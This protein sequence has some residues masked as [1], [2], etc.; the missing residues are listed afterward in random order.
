M[1]KHGLTRAEELAE[2]CFR[3]AMKGSIRHAE[4]FLNYSEGRPKQIHDLNFNAMDRLAERIAE[5]RKRVADRQGRSFSDDG[6]TV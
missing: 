1:G 6:P 4:L 3:R 2:Y 5:G